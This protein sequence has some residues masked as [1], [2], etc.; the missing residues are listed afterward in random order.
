[1]DHTV[2]EPHFWEVVHMSK[3]VRPEFTTKI[4]GRALRIGAKHVLNNSFFYLHESDILLIHLQPYHVPEQ[5]HYS[6]VQP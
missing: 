4:E 1:M 2:L 3:L 5:E 6:H